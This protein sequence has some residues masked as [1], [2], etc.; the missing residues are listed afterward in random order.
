ME[1]G[2][3]LCAP[4]GFGCYIHDGHTLKQLGRIEVVSLVAAVSRDGDGKDNDND[5]F[6][7]RRI[8][9]KSPVSIIAKKMSL[10]RFAEG[11]LLPPTKP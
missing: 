10:C 2:K 8:C 11:F 3:E 6:F 5:A 7:I 9:Y 4:M 1:G